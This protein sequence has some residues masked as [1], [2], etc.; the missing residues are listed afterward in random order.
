MHVLG[1]VNGNELLAS[2]YEHAWRWKAMKAGFRVYSLPPNIVIRNHSRQMSANR[3]AIAR[4]LTWP[5]RKAKSMW[6]LMSW[7]AGGIVVVFVMT[8]MHI[9]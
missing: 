3:Y 2:D 7:T 5:L 9:I 8:A 6:G 1:S 4:Q